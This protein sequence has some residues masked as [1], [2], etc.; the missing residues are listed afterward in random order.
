MQDLVV[1]DKVV[2]DVKRQE[3]GG[4]IEELGN[5]MESAFSRVYEKLQQVL[6]LRFFSF[7]DFIKQTC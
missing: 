6:T 2:E 3:V 7:N 5:K 1:D 4:K